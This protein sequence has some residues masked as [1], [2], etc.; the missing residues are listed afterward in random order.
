V[1]HVLS[2]LPHIM[3]FE[4]AGRIHKLGRFRGESYDRWLARYQPIFQSFGSGL[5]V[6]DAAPVVR[7]WRQWIFHP[8]WCLA[9][10]DQEELEFLRH[11]QNEI[12]ALRNANG[13]WL[14]LKG[15]LTALRQ[16]YQSP[17][18][19][20]RF[21][22]RLPLVD[23][24]S[25]VV[26]GNP[27][28]ETAYP[29]PDFSRAW[30]VTVKNLTLH[31]MVITATAIH[32]Y[33]LRHGAPPPDLEALVPKYLAKLPRDL[34]DGQA[35][36]YRLLAGTSFLLYSIGEDCQDQGGYAGANPAALDSSTSAWNGR[37]WI[38]PHDAAEHVSAAKSASR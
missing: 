25:S 5:P 1:D 36:R 19:A 15:R 37:D 31:E 18:G 21:Y 28:P 17:H 13:S 24:F 11:S 10:A 3:E 8:L 30:L 35:L 4:R 9:W 38:W 20:S 33:T 16:D 14:Q 27:L 2:Q 26:G 6:S 7:L 23:Q 32:R 22:L 12:E 29:Y 34:M